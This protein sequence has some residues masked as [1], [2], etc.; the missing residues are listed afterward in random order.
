MERNTLL[1][2][3]VSKIFAY[4]RPN[5]CPYLRFSRNPVPQKPIHA[6][7]EAHGDV[8]KYNESRL[9]LNS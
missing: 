6:A 3:S 2:Q 5:Y 7:V 9:S 4:S 8:R 1:G